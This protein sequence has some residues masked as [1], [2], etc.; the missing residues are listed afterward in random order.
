MGVF[1]DK[2]HSPIRQQVGQIALPFYWKVILP[3]IVRAIV[4]LVGIHAGIS[5]QD[6]ERFVKSMADGAEF[7]APSDVPLAK[8]CTAI[9]GL[10]Q[11][12]WEDGVGG[13][14]AGRLVVRRTEGPFEILAKALLIAAGKKSNTSWSADGRIGIA[15][16]ES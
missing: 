9:A 4:I 12:A 8:N 6:A 16:C 3:K 14:Q 10:L 7:G 11:R 15:I 5:Q 13:P 2:V 1:L